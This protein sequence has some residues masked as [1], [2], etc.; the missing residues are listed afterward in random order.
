MSRREHRSFIRLN[1][2][3]QAPDR[4]TCELLPPLGGEMEK[5]GLPT[6]STPIEKAADAMAEVTRLLEKGKPA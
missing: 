6:F 2:L 5:L 4:V 1:A 3:K